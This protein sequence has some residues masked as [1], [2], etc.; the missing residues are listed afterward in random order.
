MKLYKQIKKSFS[1]IEKLFDEQT[2]NNLAACDY[3]DLWRYHFE[4]GIRIRN[5]LLQTDS[6][7][8]QAL[9]ESGIHSK[10]DMSALIIQLFYLHLKI[11][12]GSCK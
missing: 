11:K 3:S 5:H 7:L 4:L 10:D 9:S 6:P 1:E 2:L 8:F 12:G